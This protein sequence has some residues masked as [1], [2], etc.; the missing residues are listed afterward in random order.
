MKEQYIKI[1]SN[2]TKYYYADKAF[3]I[4]H[5]DDGPAIE[6][7]DGDKSWFFDGKRHRLDG[8]AVHRLNG[9]KIW[10]VDGKRHR[11]DGPAIEWADGT[12]EWFVEHERLTESEFNDLLRPKK[13][14]TGQVVEVDGVKYKLVKD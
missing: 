7:S 13:D 11:L 3:S 1:D 6:W 12:K 9:T 2:G 10:Y 5:R 14:C 4:L 8:P